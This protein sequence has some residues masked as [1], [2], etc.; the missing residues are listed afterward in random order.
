MQSKPPLG[1]SP[2]DFALTGDPRSGDQ[3]L[4]ENLFVEIIKPGGEVRLVASVFVVPPFDRVALGSIERPLEQAAFDHATILLYGIQDLAPDYGLDI[5]ERVILAACVAD[6]AIVPDFWNLPVVG[7]AWGSGGGV[8]GCVLL[9]RPLNQPIITYVTSSRS[10]SVFSMG[11][12]TQK[13]PPPRKK[14]NR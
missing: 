11:R 2:P 9:I 6:Q 10:E 8:G 12:N 7:A 1:Q 14:N 5:H 3:P 4:R 13:R